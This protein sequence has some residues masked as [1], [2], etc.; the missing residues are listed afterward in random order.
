LDRLRCGK[1]ES[2]A[3]RE[4]NLVTLVTRL[5]PEDVRQMEEVVWSFGSISNRGKALLA[6]SEA[7]M[8]AI[9][10]KEAEDAKKATAAAKKA[11]MKQQKK[12]A[13]AREAL[14]NRDRRVRGPIKTAQKSRQLSSA[15][16]Q[17]ARLGLVEFP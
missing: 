13:V 14:I 2:A 8:D 17:R 5:K 16:Q 1:G 12:D 7:V 6:N 15:R 3:R 9:E 4:V 11:A 10:E